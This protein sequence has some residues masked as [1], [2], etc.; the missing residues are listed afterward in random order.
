[1]TV[2]PRRLRAPFR[3]ESITT[4]QAQ[5]DQQAIS[6]PVPGV[7]LAD[8]QRIGVFSELLGIVR[9]QRVLGVDERRNA[10]LSVISR[11]ATMMLP[12]PEPAISITGHAAGRQ[13]PEATS[14]AMDRSEQAKSADALT[15]SLPGI[16][17]FC[18]NCFSIWATA[19]SSAFCN[20]PLLWSVFVA[21]GIGQVGR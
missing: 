14:G 10:G 3:H 1:M 9:I 15:S 13:C 6:V 18:R 4:C 12:S 19:S 5:A 21:T 17:S 11:A 7:R 8:Q 20:L 16:T 2:P